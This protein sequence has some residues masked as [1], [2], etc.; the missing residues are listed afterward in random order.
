M[1]CAGPPCALA[2][3]MLLPCCITNL[4]IKHIT[5]LAATNMR[6]RSTC[7][8]ANAPD[9]PCQ[10]DAHRMH[11]AMVAHAQQSGCPS[12]EWIIILHAP[13]GLSPSTRLVHWLC[14]AE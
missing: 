10:R 5:E 3:N 1:R 8:T 4:H 12:R 2:Q 14:A 7:H 9:A 13:K 6:R 11:N